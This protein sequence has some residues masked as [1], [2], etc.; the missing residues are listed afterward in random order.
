M[1]LIKPPGLPSLKSLATWIGINRPTRAQLLAASESLTNPDTRVVAPG[2]F[3]PVVAGLKTKRFIDILER[4]LREKHQTSL[5][6]AGHINIVYP[7]KDPRLFPFRG[8]PA[9]YFVED[10]VES[11]QATA[12]EIAWRR[13]DALTELVH[14]D[15]SGNQS[16]DH[17]MAGRQIYAYDPYIKQD[18]PFPLPVQ[19]AVKEFFII[20]DWM[21]A[22]GTT[23]ANLNSFI[24]ANGGTVLAV[25]SEADVPLQQ[26]PPAYND[27]LIREAGL[28]PEFNDAARNTGM[29]PKLALAF[30][31]AAQKE[32]REL[33]PQQAI[34]LYEERLQPL[35]RSVF[36]MTHYEVCHA[37]KALEV[38]GEKEMSFSEL[39]KRL[40]NKAPAAK[41]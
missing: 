8:N 9:N 22:Q 2:G 28:R 16:S 34:D 25:A 38:K 36:T 6:E 21:V 19:G 11:L 33:T 3:P 40:E 31:K 12:P 30:A 24:T 4:E 26:R 32:G 5:Q 39:L 13:I 10:L 18:E 41:I 7:H 29:L 35:G 23:V 37:M 14:L 17:A 15:R 27:A 20:A 1:A